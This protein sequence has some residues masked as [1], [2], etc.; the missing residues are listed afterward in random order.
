MMLNGSS[1]LGIVISYARAG[2]GTRLTSSISGSS[3][4]HLDSCQLE[5]N[6]QS[7]GLILTGRIVCILG[8]RGVSCSEDT[9]GARA[10]V[11]ILVSNT[12]GQCSDKGNIQ[13]PKCE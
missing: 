4:R 2:F 11:L 12:H 10:T 13:E 8:V 5:E 6:L 3:S 7:I 1:T 9:R